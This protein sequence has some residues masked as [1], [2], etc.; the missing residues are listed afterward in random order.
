MI[1]SWEIYTMMD[2]CRVQDIYL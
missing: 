2:V 1:L